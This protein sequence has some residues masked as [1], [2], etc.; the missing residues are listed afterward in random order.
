[1]EIIKEESLDDLT[2]VRKA[3][4]GD[5]VS[6]EILLKRYQGMARA[7]ARKYFLTDGTFE[8]LYQEGLL[9]IFKAIQDFN[10][11]KN[12]NFPGFVSVCVGRKIIDAI[13]TST[14]E[15]HKMLS[16]AVSIYSLDENIADNY[17]GDPLSQYTVIENTEN[18]YE[19]LSCLLK[20][21]Q[22][23]ILKFYLEGYSYNEIAGKMDLPVKKIDNTLHAVKIKIKKNK[24]IFD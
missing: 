22:L 4:S 13:R 11:D 23:K 24:D 17:S 15:K 10:S 7:K 2:L 20:P 6:V 8:D 1:M 19:K 12:D 18:F 5:S 3:Q 21:A 9:G 16:N 14:R